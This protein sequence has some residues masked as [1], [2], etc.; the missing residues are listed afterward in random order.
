[1][2][3]LML[4]LLLAPQA[5]GGSTGG[6]IVDFQAAAAGPADAVSGQPLVFDGARNWQVTLS[7]ARLHIGALYLA[8]AV[9]VSGAQATSCIVPGSY[10]AQVVLGRDIDLLSSQP[11]LFPVLGQ[12]TTL[13]ANAGQVWLT[14]GDVN[15]VSDPPQ[16]TVILALSGSAQLGA[17]IRSFDAQLTIA[18]NRVGASSGVAGGAP[19]CKQRIVSPIPTSIQVENR[20]A[21]L[22]RVDPRRLFTNVD[23][24][25][26][27]ANGD[28]FSFK[29]DSSDQPSANLYNNLRQ[30]G[31]LYEFSWVPALN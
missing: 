13:E 3:R 9:P 12:G 14:G 8:E 25:A 26:L 1:M 16:P 19:I 2:R 18:D 15:Q 4:W 29:D 23:F 11:Q 7:S 21:L 17:E 31:A 5:C 27:E 28:H 6:E 24:G 10:I 20:G 22:L 30:G